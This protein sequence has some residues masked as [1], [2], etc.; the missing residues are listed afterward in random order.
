MTS[1]I[2]RLVSGPKARFT[3][4]E[5]DVEL[6]LV[7]VNPRL[8][9]MGYPASGIEGLYRNNRADVKRFLTERHGKAFWVWNFCPLS[10]S[11]GGYEESVFDGRV[12]RWPWPDHHAPPVAYL[13]LIAS[14]IRT[15][16]AGSED[17]VAVV[18]CK[19][20]K[21]R[22]GTMACAYL[23]L[24]MSMDQKTRA[25]STDESADQ[26]ADELI[27]AVPTLEDDDEAH[28]EQS[29]SQN[30][31]DTEEISESPKQITPASTIGTVTPASTIVPTST[32]APTIASSVPPSTRI[33]TESS[34][35][36]H[37][38]T[39]ALH[40]IL[41]LHTS[42]RMKPATDGKKAKQ[43]VSIPSQRRYLHYYARMLSPQPQSPSGRVRITKITLRMY[44]PPRLVRGSVTVSLAR[45]D[46]ELV[47][48][49]ET[50]VGDVLE[51]ELK[52]YTLKSPEVI[53]DARRE[54]RIKLYMG[55]LFLAWAWFIPSFEFPSPEGSY[56]LN[57]PRKSLDFPVGLGK[58]LH[59][60]DVD[61]EWVSAANQ[62]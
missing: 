2:R 23:L 15:W 22:S 36:T 20:G 43:G 49:L 38:T 55:Q 7:Y 35:S 9:I 50:H 61:M 18:H 34:K 28:V 6:D 4:A 56:T 13:P 8:I 45:Y 62:S 53:V 21:G 14:E 48:L 41:A 44:P 39:E 32:L 30:V 3:D 11:G 33:S 26:R 51:G 57:L 25:A 16:L 5:L 37:T 12:S 17:R 29:E 19:A 42:R 52:V 58:W 60:V 27:D 46:D 40:G 47:Q 59:D 54:I 31:T 24:E 10:E 1:Y